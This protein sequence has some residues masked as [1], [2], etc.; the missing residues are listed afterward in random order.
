MDTQTLPNDSQQWKVWLGTIVSVGL[1]TLAV[2][3][4]KI[5]RGMAGPRLSWDDFFIYLAWVSIETYMS[6]AQAN[7]MASFPYRA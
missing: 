6:R 4:R 5:A 2:G 7:S 3:A 1:A